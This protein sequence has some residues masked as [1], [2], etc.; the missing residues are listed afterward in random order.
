MAAEPLGGEFAVDRVQDDEVIGSCPPLVIL[1]GLAEAGPPNNTTRRSE[2]VAPVRN[3][4]QFVGEH[5]GRRIIA[6]LDLLIH[7]AV[8]AELWL[9]DALEGAR[10][11]RNAVGEV[12]GAE[13]CPV[14]II[15]HR[16]PPQPMIVSLSA[17][18][19]IAV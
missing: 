1:L 16:H 9:A 13:V 19:V 4:Q 11:D 7:P 17:A 5:V 10:L 3:V 18:R 12:V 15:A 14:N 8:L 2:L 6:A